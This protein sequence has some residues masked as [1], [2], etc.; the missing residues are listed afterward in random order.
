[1]GL[2]VQTGARSHLKSDPL[3][4]QAHAEVLE[5]TASEWMTVGE[6]NVTQVP[7]MNLQREKIDVSYA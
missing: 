4:H 2:Q 5:M 1:V 3:I 6:G 7:E